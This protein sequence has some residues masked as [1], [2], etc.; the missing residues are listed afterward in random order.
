M[1]RHLREALGDPL[2]VLFTLVRVGVVYLVLLG[3]LR[4][5]GKRVL[6]QMTPLDLLTLLLLSNVVQ[7]AMIGPD[8]SL[9]GGLLGAGLL[10]FL[11]RALSRSPLGRRIVG[12]PTLLV[13]EG[14]PIPEHLRREG[15]DLEE[16]MAALREHGILDLKDVLAA[17]LEVDGTISAIPKDHTVPK[18]VRKVRSSRNR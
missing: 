12:E 15:V 8:N 6:G 4:L 16:L 13:H 18:R 2:T 11:D 17:V 7:N 1:E 14:Q 10:L 5:S 3:Y 9:V